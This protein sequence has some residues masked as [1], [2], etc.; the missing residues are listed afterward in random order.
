R[1]PTLSRKPESPANQPAPPKA[2]AKPAS[3]QPREAIEKFIR[4]FAITEPAFLARTKPISRNAKPACMNITSRAETTTQVMSNRPRI[5]SGV[6]STF[7]LLPGGG[8]GCRRVWGA[9]APSSLAL[10]RKIRAPHPPLCPPP[11]ATGAKSPGPIFLRPYKAARATRSYSEP[12]P[13]NPGLLDK[14]STGRGLRQKAGRTRMRTR[15][16]NVTAARWTLN[17]GALGVN[18][19]TEPG[20][21]VFGTHVFTIAEQRARMPK[22]VFEK[23]MATLEAGEPMDA[24]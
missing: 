18:D 5:S 6:R 8:C 1:S 22:Q 2:I 12:R 9:Q 16:H 11:P 7:V 15:Q 23:L 14:P 3:H 10:R 21:D 17:G 4:T 13:R 20:A 24:S 19:L